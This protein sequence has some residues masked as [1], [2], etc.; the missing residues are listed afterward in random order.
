VIGIAHQ[1]IPIIAE[2]AAHLRNKCGSANPSAL[3]CCLL[4]TSPH[5]PHQS[6]TISHTG[7]ARATGPGETCRVATSIAH[8]FGLVTPSTIVSRICSRTCVSPELAPL[9]AD[10]RLA[11]AMAY[12]EVIEQSS[13]TTRS[14]L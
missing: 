8:S 2:Q 12:L 14:E 13:T 10:P 3:D 11:V 5:G 9:R 6:P 7:I 1:S 4:G